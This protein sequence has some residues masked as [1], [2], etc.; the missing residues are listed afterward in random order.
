MRITVSGFDIFLGILFH[1][2]KLK[3]HISPLHFQMQLQSLQT[4]V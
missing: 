2:F 1:A 4:I 3:Q